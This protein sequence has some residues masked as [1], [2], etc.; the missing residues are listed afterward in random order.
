MATEGKVPVRESAG[1]AVRFWRENWRFALI[2]AAIA[3]VVAT[4]VAA[5]LGQSFIATFVGLVISAVIYAALIGASLF[6][7]SAV[8][9]RLPGDAWR[10][11]ASMAV[12]GFFLFIVVMVGLI[13]AAVVLGATFAPY[14]AQMEAAGQDQ[15]AVMRVISQFA[16]ENPGVVLGVCLVY[17]AI[18]MALTSRLYLA[19]P[20]SI[21]QG[22]VLAFDTWK[23]TK[24]NMLRIAGSRLLL[25][26]PA[27]ILIAAVQ[28]IAARVLGI[29]TED[30][31]ALQSM[32]AAN[33]TMF[34]I[35]FFVS[36]FAMNALYVP[37]ESGLAAYLY[38]GLKPE[39]AAPVA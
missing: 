38:R 17:F 36:Q 32:V 5:V 33:P 10:N 1:Q 13:P 16:Q 29:P 25:L 39:S 15:A 37:L 3:S 23:W 11:F 12:I 26:A 21:D 20:A 18:W 28:A 7:A 34:L 27:M 14:M 8:Q 31:V 6:G 30:P 19:G 22:R 2:A 4:L 35:Y 24:G 9:S